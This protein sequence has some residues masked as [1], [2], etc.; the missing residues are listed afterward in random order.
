M[1]CASCALTVKK[2]LQAIPGVDNA[3]V[4]FADK[5][6]LITFHKNQTDTK[7]FEKQVKAVGYE[8]VPAAT[9][10]TK[11]MDHVEREKRRL[12]LAWAIT[13]PLTIKMLLEMF[14][15]IFIVY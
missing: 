13:I 8:L 5:K 1:S 15:G 12:I 11:E 2:A 3:V 6:A 9:L 4:N 7:S 10:K 14:F